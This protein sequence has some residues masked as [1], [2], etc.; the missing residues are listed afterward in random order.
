M[1]E[2]LSIIKKERGN[3]KNDDIVVLGN[4][5]GD[6]SADSDKLQPWADAGMTWWLENLID[7]GKTPEDMMKRVKQ[8]PPEL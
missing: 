5:T 3:L 1:E 6:K 7:W 8:G 4:T 2:S